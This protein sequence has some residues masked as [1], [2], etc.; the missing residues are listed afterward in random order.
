MTFE[1]GSGS[2]GIEKKENNIEQPG[3]LVLPALSQTLVLR[4]F[5]LLGGGQKRSTSAFWGPKRVDP[6]VPRPKGAG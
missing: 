6:D 2:I 5:Q 1:G 3:F 4:D